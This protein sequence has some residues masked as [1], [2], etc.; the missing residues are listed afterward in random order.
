MECE[1]ALD[2]QPNQQRVPLTISVANGKVGD[3]KAA[4]KDSFHWKART[5]ENK[6]VVTPEALTGE[7]T[8]EV[9]DAQSVTAGVYTFT[10]DGKVIGNKVA[11]KFKSKL[12]EKEIRPAAMFTGNVK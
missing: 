6:L 11:G 12:G 4:A 3:V 7:L 2:G 5:K 9:Y 8:I 1:R 10:F